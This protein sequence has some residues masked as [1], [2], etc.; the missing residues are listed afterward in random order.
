MDDPLLSLVLDRID[1]DQTLDDQTGLLVLAGCLGELDM[2]LRDEP[3]SRPDV[4]EPACTLAT[5]G[6]YG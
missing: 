2:A 1:G 5:A 4:A 6:A 3:V